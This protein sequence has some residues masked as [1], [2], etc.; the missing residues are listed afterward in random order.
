MDKAGDGVYRQVDGDLDNSS[1]SSM[2]GG[3]SVDRRFH[4]SSI[5]LPS[6]ESFIINS[7][8]TL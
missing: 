1:M 3:L 4:D 8:R 2:R 5:G 7:Y 6:S